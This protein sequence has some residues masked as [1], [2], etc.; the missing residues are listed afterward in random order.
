MRSREIERIRE[1]Y[2]QLHGCGERRIDWAGVAGWVSGVMVL[3]LINAA[4]VYGVVKLI[5]WS[6]GS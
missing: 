4:V 3:I 5:R 1:E 6:W 2:W